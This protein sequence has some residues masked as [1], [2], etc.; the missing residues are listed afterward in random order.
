[1]GGSG[2]VQ[3][4][5]LMAEEVVVSAGGSG[6]ARVHA[7]RQLRAAIAGSGSV[8]YSGNPQLSQSIAGSGTL[9]RR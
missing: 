4:D 5:S 3:A 7:E 6:N 2:D 8:I 1:V 9:R